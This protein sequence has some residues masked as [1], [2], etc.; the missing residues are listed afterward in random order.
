MNDATSD[1]ASSI[2][3]YE[4]NWCGYCR[5]AKRLL[6]TKGWEYESIVVDGDASL[7]EQM[8]AR[9]GRTSVPQIFFGDRH[10]GGFDDLAELEQNGELDEAYESIGS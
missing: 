4:S 7:R 8:T 10:I 5:A 9:A 3:M 6:A 1:S 2:V